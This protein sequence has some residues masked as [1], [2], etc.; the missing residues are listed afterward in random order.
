MFLRHWPISA[1]CSGGLSGVIKIAHLICP[2]ILSR[3]EEAAMKSW[4]SRCRLLLFPTSSSITNPSEIHSWAPDGSVAGVIDVAPLMIIEIGYLLK[5][6]PCYP[7]NFL[8]QCSWVLRLLWG[9]FEDLVQ[10]P[11]GV[12]RPPLTLDQEP[13]QF[14]TPLSAFLSHMHSLSLFLSYWFNIYRL[15]LLE[16]FPWN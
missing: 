11:T 14:C 1:S 12:H 16:S 2:L 5:G 10:N 8:G 3:S 4:A 9:I 15:E 13:R 7:F 6:K